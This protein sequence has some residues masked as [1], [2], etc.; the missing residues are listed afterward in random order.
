MLLVTTRLAADQLN[1]RKLKMFGPFSFFLNF[2]ITAV[3]M[4]VYIGY[5]SKKNT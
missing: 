3:Y 2:N 1:F 4:Y 5:N